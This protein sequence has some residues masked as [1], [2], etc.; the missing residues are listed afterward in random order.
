MATN[1]CTTIESRTHIVGECENIQ[2]GT[3]CVR[4]GDEEI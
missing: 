4:G 2:R 1:I 3:G